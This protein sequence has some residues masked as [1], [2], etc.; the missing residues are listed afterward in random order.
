MFFQ[1]NTGL[2]NELINY[3]EKDKKEYKLLRDEWISIYD[4]MEQL[5]STFPN[6]YD[7]GTAWTVILDN[8]YIKYA[9]QHKIPL[10][11][12]YGDDED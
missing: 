8:F 11:E 12:G 5:G 9:K 1:S 7:L 10:P 2:I 4:F 6:G 3:L